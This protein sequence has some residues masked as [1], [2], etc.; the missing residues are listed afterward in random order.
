MID[1]HIH[2]DD[3]R[4]NPDRTELLKQARQ[5]GITG[6]VVPAVAKDSI[7]K[8]QQL[9]DA[10]DDIFAAFGLHP[11]FCQ[12]HT[13]SDLDFLVATI[14]KHKPVALGE[15]GL[16]YY[17]SDLDKDKQQYFFEAQVEMAKAHQLPLILHVN[18]AV[19]A[20]FEVL[21]K[22]DYFNAVMHSFNGSIEQA[23]Q[24]TEAGIILGFGT[25]AVN[26]RAHKLQAM[27]KSV[28]VECMV[29]ETDAPDQ[30]LYDQKHERN[31]PRCLTQVV[32]GIAR[33]KSMDA[34]QLGTQTTANCKKLF[35]L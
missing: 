18:G 9:A 25:A 34:T 10:H 11:Y 24:I 17:R 22:Y 2:V 27:V 3:K 7:I 21:N 5:A 35:S 1:S 20:V 8:V 29:V 4:F 32:D 30:P 12:T 15:C 26:P 28:A 16:D 23:R 19:Q 14:E 31:L 33:I 6:F 13:K